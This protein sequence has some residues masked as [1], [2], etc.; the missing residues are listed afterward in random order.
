MLD[1]ARFPEAHFPE[2]LGEYEI[3]GRLGRGGS[4][5]VL[6]VRNRTTGAS[7]AA[8][9]IMKS[10][11]AVAR[12]RF[13]R[14][15]ELLARCDRHPGV[16]KVHAFGETADG[17]PY[18]VMDLVRG[19]GLDR[20]LERE[21][22][23]EPRRAAALG[24]DV[25]AALG[26]AHSLGIV[27][28]D[29]KPSNV[30]LD[31]A[32]NVKLTDFGLA[33]ACDLERL[34]RTGIFLGTVR[35]CAPEQA[36]TEAIGPP[37]D[38]F[39]TGCLLFHALT[40]RAP[41][42]HLESPAAV[43]KALRAEEPLADV[44]T[45][46]PS[47]P[48][49]LARIV[50]CA[51]EKDPDLR[52]ANGAELA[53]DL[54]HFLAGEA[55]SDPDRPA[56]RR[57][58]QARRA[59]VVALGLAL[60]G[61]LIASIRELE[62]TIGAR[63][64]LAA[65]SEDLAS[66]S[67]ILARRDRPLGAAT[68]SELVLALET[69]RRARDRAVEAAS[70]GASADETRRAADAVVHQALGALAARHLA[71]GDAAA[72]L[73][74]LDSIPGAPGAIAPE[75]RLD[76]ARALFLLGRLDA[77]EG[78][79]LGALALGVRR[80]EALELM[81]DAF[82]AA[83]DLTRAMSAYAAALEVGA[84]RQ[85][86]LHRKRGATAA[87][88]GDD[89]LALAELAALVPDLQALSPDRAA[90]AALV[91]LAPSLYR[92][93]LARSL[94]TCEGD[95]E[96]ASRL[97]AP[98]PALAVEV[99]TRW[100]ELAE[101]AARRWNEASYTSWDEASVAKLRGALVRFE[102]AREAAPATFA[103]STLWESCTL[104]WDWSRN[105]SLGPGRRIQLAR[106]LLAALPGHPFFL[107]F[108][109]RALRPDKLDPQ[110][111]LT[112]EQQLARRAEALELVQQAA[113][114]LPLPSVEPRI[115]NLAFELAGVLV[116][117]D[118]SGELELDT[119]RLSRLADRGEAKDSFYWYFVAHYLHLRGDDAKA[120]EA[121]ERQPVG[122]ATGLPPHKDVASTHMLLLLK[123]GRAERAVEVAR[124][125]GASGS[126]LLLAECRQIEDELT[127]AGA[128]AEPAAALT[129]GEVYALLGRTANAESALGRLRNL[130][131]AAEAAKL[132]SLIERAKR[133][134]D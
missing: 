126:A 108:L 15:A 7:Y 60:L 133:G 120:L 103:S 27:H 11:D 6:E 1:A 128:S 50:G 110:P 26:H 87:L 86:E 102:H 127:A 68:H 22:R 4:G 113:D 54:S 92:R 93:A 9:L 90:N 88:A 17:V 2:S 98:P 3:V 78:A 21:D 104:L 81:G 85:R 39:A 34:T 117:I 37:A 8:K 47:C 67:S 33:T 109:A 122:S 75:E 19:E 107:F 82:R 80:A 38:V 119:G 97:A 53:L 65:S 56:R 66:A 12:E 83:G 105:V 44:R 30:L 124:R 125:D 51:L 5:V 32:G 73:A 25:A 62:R 24:R 84:A 43:F 31:E 96:A 71:L 59:L 28:R 18:M 45:L 115:G 116:E 36:A 123:N 49:P 72:A 64:A 55:T 100:L 10:N 61:V 14:E 91:E 130:G 57:R 58:R 94:E 70:L 42:E 63:A 23:L 76:R 111:T 20:L 41:L 77:N 112:A 13:R 121:M 132:E 89:A 48:E 134:G 29:V 131:A 118:V 106:S 79:A 114:R 52:Y 74:L 40:G 16:V 101:P 129:L 46:E 95:L 99:G 35:Y 69:S